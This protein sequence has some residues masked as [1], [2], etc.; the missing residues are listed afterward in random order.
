[1]ATVQIRLVIHGS[2]G[3]DDQTTFSK[4]QRNSLQALCNQATIY[5]SRTWEGSPKFAP[6]SLLTPHISHDD[7]GSKQVDPLLSLYKRIKSHSTKVSYTIH[8]SPS[9]CSREKTDLTIRGSL[10]SSHRS[11]LT[12]FFFSLGPQAITV[13]RSIQPIDFCALSRLN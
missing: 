1:M 6:F 13:A 12:F 10:A 9:L 8:N 2:K 4:F 3:T 11:P 7:S 5:H